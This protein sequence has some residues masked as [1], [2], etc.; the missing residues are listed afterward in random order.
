MRRLYLDYET[1]SSVTLR[2]G[3]DVYLN[4]A[5]PTLLTWVWDDGPVEVFDFESPYPSVFDE[6]QEPDVLCIAHNAFFDRLVTARHVLDE[7]TVPPLTRWHCTYAQALAHGLPGGL[8]PLCNVL[9]VPEHLTKHDGRALI[10]KFCGPKPMPPK[11][12]DWNL[13]VQYAINDTL[14][15]RECHR[16][17]PNWNYLGWEKGVWDEDQAINERGFAVDLKLADAMIAAMEEE[18]IRHAELANNLTG[19]AVTSVTQRDKFLLYL[20]E[21]QGCILPDLRAS[22]I[23]LALE[24]ESLEQA[25]KELLYLRLEGSKASTAKYKRIAAA[26]G[27][28]SRL[29][30]ALQYSGASRTGRWAGRV[31]QPQNLPRV[32]EDMAPYVAP[33]IDAIVDGRKD[34]VELFAPLTEMGSLALRGLIVAPEGKKLVI[35]DYSA[36][37]GRV[38]PWLAGEAWKLE[39]FKNGSDLYKVIYALSFAMKVEDVTKEQRKVGKVEELAL[40]YQG[41]VGAF[42]SMAAGYSVDLEDIGRLVPI[43]MESA[44]Q[45]EWA[46]KKNNTFGLSETVWRACATICNGYR[47]ANP[48]IVTFWGDLENAAIRAIGN[49][50]T[51]QVGRLVFDCNGPWLRIKLPSGRY[52]CYALPHLFPTESKTIISYMG[53]RNKQW[54]RTKTYGGK[55]AENVTQAVARDLL[56][57]ALLRLIGTEYTTV[58]HVHDEIVAETEPSASLEKFIAIMAQAPAW[59]EGLPLKAEGFEGRRY[60]K[61]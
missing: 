33:S 8:G 44:R 18:R 9:G 49:R 39:A 12:E 4:H 45:W 30:G 61:R 54:S 23:E 10:A 1:W 42:I 14:A 51:V 5:R 48:N 21:S 28:G 22:T 34:I 32:P 52:L 31:F 53:W 47:K 29:R 46:V 56:A 57:Q 41:F 59:A 58:L 43:D 24:D 27:E 13:F 2:N 40:G 20:C 50:E 7:A 25:T 35:A 60:E 36:I 55:L 38:L 11:D 15:A 19:G 6:M 16:R 37:E 26:A 3:T 17:M